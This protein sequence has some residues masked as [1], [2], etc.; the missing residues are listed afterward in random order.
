LHT[1]PT[2]TANYGTNNVTVTLADGSTTV[3]SLGTFNPLNNQIMQSTWLYDTDSSIQKSF[4]LVGRV[5]FKMEGD[6]FNVFNN[7]GRDFSPNNSL[8]DGTG[9][10]LTN[11]NMNSPRQV[12]ISAHLTF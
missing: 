7:P 10:V 2:D 4:N 1:D 9:I 3:T 6:F 8:G 11:Y 12:Q 5:R